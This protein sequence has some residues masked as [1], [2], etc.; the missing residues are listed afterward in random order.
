MS[1]QDPD[2][3]NS[4][5]S[6]WKNLEKYVCLCVFPRL[7]AL[8]QNTEKKGQA[9]WER[10]RP[11][12]R[13]NKGRKASQN[14]LTR[15]LQ[16]SR[17][18]SHV[19]CSCSSS[20]PT[21]TKVH[22]ECMAVLKTIP[23]TNLFG[24]SLSIIWYWNAPIIDKYFGGLDFPGILS[25][26]IYKGQYIV[27]SRWQ[28]QGLAPELILCWVQSVTATPSFMYSFSPGPARRT[29]L[30]ACFSWLVTCGVSVSYVWRERKY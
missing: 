24:L 11:S 25:Y 17:N 16:P 8:L 21:A 19:E 9:L 1:L 7:I 4:S 29:S 28:G 26:L 12:C 3:E 5:C 15:F 23:R 10:G 13:V 20:F 30:Q 18:C 22:V 14:Q 2:W 6:N 27:S